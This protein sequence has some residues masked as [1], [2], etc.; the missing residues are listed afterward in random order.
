MSATSRKGAPPAFIL[1]APAR[2]NALT[3]AMARDLRIVARGRNSLRASSRSAC[4]PELARRTAASMR[5]ELGPPA[6]PWPAALELERSA[7]MWSMRRR[8]LAGA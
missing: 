6:L 2:R 5:L 4:T 7:Q 1:D 8:H 3:V